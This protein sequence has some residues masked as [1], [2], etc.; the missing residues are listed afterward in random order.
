MKQDDHIVR[1]ADRRRMTGLSKITWWRY[2]RA[3]TAPRRIQLGRNSIGW[4][5][6][7]LEAW[8]A[9]RAAARGQAQAAGDA[10]TGKGVR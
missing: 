4:L 8:V 7:E 9:E 2:E 1:E 6:S 10:P 5:R 3:G